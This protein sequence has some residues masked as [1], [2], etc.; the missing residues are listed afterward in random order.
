MTKIPTLS[1]REIEILIVEDEMLLAMGMK[2]SLYNFG[3]EVSGIEVTGENAIKHIRN[4]KPDLILMD[5]HL[6][7]NINGIETAKYIWQSYKIPII[8]LTSYNDQKTI[9]EAMTSEPYAYL[10]KPCKDEE[11]LAAITTSIHKHN[12][13]FKNKDILETTHKIQIDENYFFNKSKAI[14]YKNNHVIKLTGNETK[15][16]EILSDYIGEPVSFERIID[17]IY[18]DTYSDISKLR[19]MIYRLKNKLGIEIIENIYEVGYKLKTI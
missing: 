8:F 15:L 5:I 19:M 1:A 11:L 13:F 9:N 10:I 6:K 14:L 12:Y 4:K 17:Y 3:Y 7:G 16:L 2:C 18:R